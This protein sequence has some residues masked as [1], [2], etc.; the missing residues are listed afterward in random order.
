MYKRAS[1]PQAGFTMIEVM[2]FLAITGLLFLI[3]FWGTGFQVRNVRFTDGMR[4]LNS[5]LQQQYNLVATGA[6][7][8]EVTAT[9]SNPGGGVSTPPS[10]GTGGT[11]TTAG[12]SGS[13]VLLGKLMK[14]K[15]GSSDLVTY[16]V[17][18]KR[19][20]TSQLTGDDMTDLVNS[21]PAISPQATETYNVNW[22]LT[23]LQS[24]TASPNNLSQ[25]FAFLR[26]PSSGKILSF[27]F[28]SNTIDNNTAYGNDSQLRV[29]GVLSSSTAQNAGFCFKDSSDHKAIINLGSGQ[30]SNALDLTF[31]AVNTDNDCVRSQP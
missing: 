28:S 4:D 6:N 30:R 10:F 5:Y 9:C 15:P 18:G 20:D 8:R 1:R 27:A 16:Y 7:P 12:S 2:L 25:A 21:S 23:F 14:F 19:L 29:G 31:D 26:S 24:G 3:G 13:C 11:T 22:G 17:V